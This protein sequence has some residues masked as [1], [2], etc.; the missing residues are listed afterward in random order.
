MTGCG[1]AGHLLWRFG[2]AT[3]PAA[4]V[5]ELCGL[6][7]LVKFIGLTEFILGCAESNPPKGKLW[8]RGTLY[9]PL[10]IRHSKYVGLVAFFQ[11]RQIPFAV[12]Y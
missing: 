9:Y 5:R 6:G 4:V 7:K 1:D 2:I 12:Q 11:Y 8:R 10:N 3:P